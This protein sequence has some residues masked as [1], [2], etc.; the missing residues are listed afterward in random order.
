[1]TQD[2]I[3]ELRHEVRT[4][5]NH[6]TAYS[7]LLEDDIKDVQIPSM[8]P[9]IQRVHKEGVNLEQLLQ[10]FFYGDDGVDPQLNRF[11]KSIHSPIYTIIGLTEGLIDIA[12]ETNTDFFVTDLNK[13]V[14]SAN[15]LLQLFIAPTN[16]AKEFVPID[17][18]QKVI[19]NFE[20]ATLA[21]DFPTITGKILIVDDNALNRDI[22][23]RHLERQGHKV[24]SVEGGREALDLLHKSSVDLILLDIMMPDINGYQ[25][26]EEVKN[27]PK[28]R[29]IPVIMISALDEMESVIRCIQMGAEDYL[30]KT[31][32]P[33]LLKARI[34]ACLEKKQLRDQEAMYISALI[35]SQENLESE[36]AEAASYVTSLLPP[37]I[38]E[39]GIKTNWVFIPSTQLGGDSFGYHKLDKDHFAFYLLDVSGHGIG[40]ALLSVSV[41]NVLRTQSLPQTNFH[42]P[43]DVL[44]ALSNNFQMEKQN[45]MYFTVWYGVLNIKTNVMEYGSAGAPPA[46]LVSFNEGDEVQ[47][48]ELASG[49]MI[50]GLDTEYKY[51]TCTTTVQPGDRIYLFSDGVFE[52][53]Q[54]NGKMLEFSDFKRILVQSISKGDTSVQPL[55]LNIKKTS[56]LEFFEDDFS[57]LEL[58]FDLNTP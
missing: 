30:P 55:Y 38:T 7:E 24:V 45:N 4:F 2:S 26:L 52:I 36:L 40:A 51:K 39:G 6:I 17:V 49:D 11:A 16:T 44:R 18:P 19:P 48:E 22:L 27:S 20:S 1:M 3:A 35:E 34:G 37:P 15:S 41:M 28:T 13:I 9:D 21:T 14:Q 46:M 56:E 10:D 42:E 8:I 32:D 12:H 57:L 29:F 50:I 54:S 58:I 47:L 25:V 31:F 23:S 43:S 53:R 5:V 33:I